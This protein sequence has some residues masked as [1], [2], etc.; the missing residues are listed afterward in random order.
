VSGTNFPPGQKDINAI[1]MMT[2]ASR[3][4]KATDGRD[5]IAMFFQ[6]LEGTGKVVVPAGFGDL[7]IE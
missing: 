7:V 4:V 1:V 5:G 2:N 6:W 3:V